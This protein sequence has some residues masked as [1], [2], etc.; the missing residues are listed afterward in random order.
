MEDIRQSPEYA[1]FM[2]KLG[3]MVERVSSSNHKTR[4]NIFIRRFPL[5][6][7]FIKVLRIKPPVLFDK[8]EDIAKKY[9]AYRVQI[10]P[11]IINRH[12]GDP[13]KSG[14]LQ[15]PPTSRLRRTGR[16]WTSQND[17]NQRHCH[18]Q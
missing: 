17:E 4:H 5:L 8:I 7:S 16:F 18:G 15:N 14:R 13:A 12:S 2:E 11:N 1:V 3:W 10:E 6:G 9:K